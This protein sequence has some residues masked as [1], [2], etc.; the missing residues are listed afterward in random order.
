[1]KEKDI[2]SNEHTERKEETIFHVEYTWNGRQLHSQFKYSHTQ[3][4]CGWCVDVSTATAANSSRHSVAIATE[5]IHN[6]NIN[7]TLDFGLSAIHVACMHVSWHDNRPLSRSF[8]FCCR[9][10]FAFV[11]F[12]IEF[13]LVFVEVVLVRFSNSSY[14]FSGKTIISVECAHIFLPGSFEF[15][16]R[17]CLYTHRFFGNCSTAF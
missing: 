15:F 2:E 3:R 7:S 1:M 6:N 12:S 16:R 13:V 5:S 14:E 9:F 4:T 10:F 17:N 8:S 11:R